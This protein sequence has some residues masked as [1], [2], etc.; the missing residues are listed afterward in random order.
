MFKHINKLYLG[1]ALLILASCANRSRGPQGGPRDQKAPQTV[2][3]SPANGVKNFKA[4][5]IEVEFNEFIVL[6]NPQEKVIVS[7]PQV[8]PPEV[9][10]VGKKIY[11]ELKDSLKPNTTYSIDFTNSIGDYTENNRQIDYTYSFSTG[12]TLDTLRVSGTVLDAATLN[13]IAN[14][15][16]GIYDNLEPS[17]F[18]KTAPIRISKTDE[19]GHFCI[20]NIKA[21]I[22]KIYA[23]GDLNRDYFFNDPNELIAFGETTINPRIETITVADTIHLHNLGE[24]HN[25][26]IIE[27]EEKTFAPNDIILKAYKTPVLKHYFIKSERKQ[28]QK[29]SFFFFGENKEH[30]QIKPLNFIASSKDLIVHSTKG[31][32]IHYWLSDSTS[33][34]NDTLKFA[35]SYKKP[36]STGVM[37]SAID[38]TTAFFKTQKEGFLKKKKLPKNIQFLDLKT[39][40]NASLDIYKPIQISFN[41]PI[42]S[43]DKS[44]IHLFSKIDSIWKEEQIAVDQTDSIGMLYK[45]NHKWNSELSYRLEI[46]SASC[47]SMYNIHNNKIKQEFKV[48]GTNEYATLTV[49]M[50]KPN[51]NAII[52]LLNDKDAVVKQ[53]RAIAKGTEFEYINPGKYYLRLFIDENGNGK[54]DLGDFESNKQPEAV[55]YFNTAIQLRANWEVEQDWDYTQPILT[56]QKPSV[57]IP[58][59]KK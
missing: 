51:E 24:E 7:P 50:I 42:K 39:N 15:Q 22:Y 10:A 43:I 35:I 4:K 33:F 6:D 1:I 2:Y 40:V 20:K 59:A 46:D 31:D 58:K 25:D 30:A 45:I 47:I 13:P 3:S 41:E 18:T 32:T 48:R 55:Y 37:V 23:L 56:K 52:E 34:K 54:W 12:T 8:K 17:A 21:G 11:I 53:Q 14:V 26:S 27:H 19:M 57:L 44:K 49:T 28:A 5:K 16:V 36:D 38:T 9:R 29:V